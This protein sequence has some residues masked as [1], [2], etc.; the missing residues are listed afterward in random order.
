MA[1]PRAQKA[2]GGEEGRPSS[3][4][5]ASAGQYA[6]VIRQ[7]TARELK[8][9]YARSYLG[10]LWSVLNPLLSMAVLSLIFSQLFRR[11]IEN[12]PIYYLTGYLVWQ[13]FTGATTAAMTTLVDNRPLLLRVKFPM[14][15]FILTRVYTALINLGYSLAAYAVM[16]AVFRVTPKAAM[17][18]SPLILLCLFAFSLGMSYL[19]AAAYVF[20]GDVKHLYTVALTLWMYCS[21]IFYPADQ[22]QGFIRTVIGVNPLFLFIDGLRGLVMRGEAPGWPAWAQMALWGGGLYLAGRAVFRKNRNRIIQK[23]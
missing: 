1:E 17:L 2:A 14:E 15:L 8:R 9:K 23:L 18:L 11:S 6:F 5:R 3:P 12:Y 21:A 19:L 20:F 7:L 13:T 22:L 16:L 10:V 4:R